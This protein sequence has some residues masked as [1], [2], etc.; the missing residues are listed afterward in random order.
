MRLKRWLAQIA[1]TTAALTGLATAVAVGIS[2][3]AA[4][5]SVV[6]W[7]PSNLQSAYQLPT[8][9]DPGL[10]VAVVAP[11]NDANAATDLAAYRSNY[12]LST[13]NATG[14]CFTEFDEGGHPITSTNHPTSEPSPATAMSLDAISA[15][16]AS[17]HLLLVEA[18]STQMTDIGTAV[19]EAVALGAKAVTVAYRIDEQSLT[20]SLTGTNETQYDSYL[21]HPGVAITAPDGDSGYG[22]VSYPAASPYVV[23]VGGTTLAHTASGARS[24]TET[25]TPGTGSGCSQYEPKPSWQ[26]DTY[27][28]GR[29]LNDTAAVDNGV[30]YYDTSGGTGWETS[31][32]DSTAEAA[33]IV[34]GIYALGGAPAPGSYPASYLY[35]HPGGLWHITGSDG[36]SCVPA[37]LCTA[38]AGYTGPAG[39]G[40]PNGDTSFNSPGAKPASVTDS[41]GNTWAFATT[42]AGVIEYATMPSDGI[43]PITN[44]TGWTSL[45]PPSQGGT[46]SGYPG[47]L[48]TSDNIVYVFALDGGVL[49]DDSLTSGSTTWS[50]WNQI[51]GSD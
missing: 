17:C 47:A 19:A 15:V 24:W 42:T 39:M 49:Y 51:G 37:Q 43:A 14:S 3:Q 48:I 25:V 35:A 10:T 23:A 18:A 38:G 16:C 1:V 31:T 41:S 45:A 4:Q 27:C 32:G 33:A 6:G 7:G 22:S 20:N 44:W 11:Y 13:C 9:L 40:V 26:T 30:A 12:G 46:F 36:T 21:N 28:S 8:N 5:A 29:T 50:G 34:A 2:T